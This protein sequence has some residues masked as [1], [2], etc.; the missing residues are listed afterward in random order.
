MHPCLAARRLSFRLFTMTL[1]HHVMHVSERFDSSTEFRH[2][3]GSGR[4]IN[5]RHSSET[6]LARWTD[7]D[8]KDA[9]GG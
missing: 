4:N 7:R 3:L 5:A 1:Q 9:F 2:S 8:L 6:S